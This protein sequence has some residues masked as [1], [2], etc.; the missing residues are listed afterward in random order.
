MFAILVVGPLWAIGG[1][2]HQKLNPPVTR[3]HRAEKFGPETISL[4]D[5]APPGSAA[6]VL[7]GV[8][9]R[10]RHRGILPSVITDPADPHRTWWFWPRVQQSRVWFAVSQDHRVRW[11][12]STVKALA[13]S[14]SVPVP[15]R[16]TAQWVMSLETGHGVIP[17]METEPTGAFLT[18]MGMATGIAGWMASAGPTPHSLVLTWGLRGQANT[19]LRLVTLW[20]WGAQSGWQCTLGVLQSEPSMA[21]TVPSIPWDSPC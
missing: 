12:A 17:A 2:H 18:D 6:W 1:H 19:G 21:L 9:T 8:P 11:Q 7:D 5:N 4:V 15:L 13:R 16:L 14:S 10:W 20:R 3:R